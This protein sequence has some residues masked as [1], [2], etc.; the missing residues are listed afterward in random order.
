MKDPKP[1][2]VFTH[3]GDNR[4]F[5]A[6]LNSLRRYPGSVVAQTAPAYFREERKYVV[7]VMDGQRGEIPIRSYY[8]SEEAAA[9]SAID[10]VT[11]K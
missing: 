2:P 5:A 7:H 6:F 9:Q 1:I 11:K 8:F 4:E 3:D 10:Y